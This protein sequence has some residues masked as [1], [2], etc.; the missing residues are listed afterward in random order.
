MID[1]GDGGDASDVTVD[2]DVPTDEH[3]ADDGD[4]FIVADSDEYNQSR[5]LKAIH[6]ARADVRKA[7]RE[8]I[9]VSDDGH[10]ELHTCRQ[11]LASRVAFYGSEL[12]PLMEEVGWSHEFPDGFPWDTL[13][14]FLRTRGRLP[15]EVAEVRAEDDTHGDYA[16]VSETES[17]EAFRVLNKF[18]REAGLGVDLEGSA[19]EWE[20]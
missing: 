8:L 4:T 13:D 16:I 10:A 14:D 20:V 15:K 17:M 7:H 19:D 12:C 3:D 9:Y 11:Q 2:V 18:A 1:G 5:R 6:Q